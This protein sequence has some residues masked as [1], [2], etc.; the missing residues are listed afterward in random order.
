MQYYCVFFTYFPQPDHRRAYRLL[1]LWFTFCITFVSITALGKLFTSHHNVSFICELLRY[2]S[3]PLHLCSTN[4]IIFITGAVIDRI[5]VITT[6]IILIISAMF[7][8]NQ[9]QLPPSLSRSSFLMFTCGLDFILMYLQ[10]YWIWV[11]T[12]LTIN[13]NWFAEGGVHHS[14]TAST[15]EWIL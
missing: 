13:F 10:V 7:T 4:T 9:L 2:S 8:L 15:Y 11:F 12:F 14:A 3:L 6:A 1:L 5:N